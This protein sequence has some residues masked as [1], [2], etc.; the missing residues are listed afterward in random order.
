MLSNW[1]V[2]VLTAAKLRERFALP[3]MSVDTVQGFR[4]KQLMKERVAAAGIRV[5]RSARARSIDEVR[6][7]LEITGYPAILKP[8]SGAGSADTYRVDDKAELERILPLLR[9]VDEVSCEE[10]I[11]GEELR[12]DGGWTIW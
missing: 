2:M 11:T 4:D 9:H 3:G 10:F 1:E 12:V 8:I 7:A 6:G 5:P